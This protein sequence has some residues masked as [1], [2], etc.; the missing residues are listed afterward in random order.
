[1][2][3]S[4]RVFRSWGLSDEYCFTG[5]E[6]NQPHGGKYFEKEYGECRKPCGG[7]FYE[8]WFGG[9]IDKLFADWP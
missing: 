5:A 1:M 7:G 8:Y 3:K 2:K 4:G 6:G 9:P